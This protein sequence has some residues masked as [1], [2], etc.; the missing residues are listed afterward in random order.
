M[1]AKASA[2]TI[3]LE[4][5]HIG[6]RAENVQRGACDVFCRFAR[7]AGAKAGKTG[8]DPLFDILQPLPCS[9]KDSAHVV[10]L[11]PSTALFLCQN[12]EVMLEF[13]RNFSRRQQAAPRCCQLNG[14]WHPFYL[15]ADREYVRHVSGAKR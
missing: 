11:R 8:K 15:P 1:Q 6:Q 14:Q 3:L 7:K 12:V 9:L 5:R 2:A 13:K 4:K 10:M